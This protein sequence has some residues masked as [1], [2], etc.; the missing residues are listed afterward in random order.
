[1]RYRTSARFERDLKRLDPIRKDRVQASIDRLVA[2]F[3]TGQLA[4]GLGLK[5]LR[6]GLWELRAGLFD[7]VVFYRASD[8]VE[9]LLVGS[10]EEIKQFLKAL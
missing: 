9:F 1:M 10:H 2:G 8:V 4:H 3:E 6:A 5:R 7:R